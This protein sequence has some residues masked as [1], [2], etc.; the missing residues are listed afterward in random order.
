LIQQ[1]RQSSNRQIDQTAALPEGVRLDFD[2]ADERSGPSAFHGQASGRDSQVQKTSQRTV[3]SFQHG[4]IRAREIVRRQTRSG[5]TVIQRSAQL[6]GLVASGS[7]YAF[8]L[9]AH[10]GVE[11]Y[12]RGR[13][14]EDIRQELASRQPPIRMAVSSLWDQQQKFLFYLGRLHEEAGPILRQHLAEQGLVSWLLDGTAEP[15]TP[16]F[17][18]IQDARSGILLSSGKI[19]SENMAD[20]A[21]CLQQAAARY[22]RPDRALHDLSPM[23]SRAC[24]EALRGVPHFVCHYH[25]ARD[26]GGDLYHKP[27][28]ALGKRMRTLKLQFRL[29]EQRRGQNEWLRQQVDSPAQLVLSQLLAGRQ[30][31]G[32]FRLALGREVLL[33]FHFWILD[34]RSDGR[35]RGFPF[36]PYT[37]Y[38]HRR[39]VRAGEAVDR[40]L[41]CPDVARQAPQVLFNFQEQL[42]QYRSD[43]EI[44]AA[45][46]L[47]ERSFSTFTRLREALRLA[48]DDMDNLRQPHELPA[49]EQQEMKTG[50]D[51]LRTQLRQQS[52]EESDADRP[53]AEVVLAHLDKYWPYLAPDRPSAEEE[54]WERTTNKLESRW[55]AL[56]R[57]RRQTHGRGKLTRDFQALPEEYML[58]ANLHNA[59]YTKLVLDAS[60]DNLPSKLA[61]ASRDAGAFSAWRQRRCP[62]LLGRPSRRLIRD[63]DFIDDVIEACQNHCQT[64]DKTAA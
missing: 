11:S 48:A 63:D 64:T 62:P 26:V 28:A 37:L 9:I 33:A 54:A 27:Q 34:Y 13:S 60:L 50:L 58:V 8:D 29:R 1:I 35:R 53:L 46:D 20:I 49:A 55:G 30:V 4:C 61:D 32:P 31:D 25:L 17:L 56:K 36:D 23:M 38:L 24:D 41:S 6:A 52:Q 18:G 42:A 5:H 51:R 22:G 19:P 59:T 57:G 14:L 12:L 10:V 21:R 43:P 47:Y 7:R 3:V 40:L 16:V 44:V 15:G 39:L 2:A 45:A